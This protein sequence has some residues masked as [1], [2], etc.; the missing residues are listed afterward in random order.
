MYFEHAHTMF[1]HGLAELQDEG[2]VNVH[3]LGAPK[4]PPPRSL[5]LMLKDALSNKQ[6]STNT[7]LGL[8]LPALQ[9]QATA[10]MSQR[11]AMSDICAPGGLTTAVATSLGL[12]ATH[13]H[14][15]VLAVLL[16]AWS[17]LLG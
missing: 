10:Y 4:G 9:A 15:Q 13:G 14:T 3:H 11:T 5:Q 1:T 16:L 7:S 12:H 17:T 6:I 2:A 8:M